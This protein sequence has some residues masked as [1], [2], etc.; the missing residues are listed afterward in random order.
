MN[1]ERVRPI[2]ILLIEDNDGDVF[3][4]RKAFEMAGFASNLIVAS[5]GETALKMLRKQEQY[6]EV[7]T[8]DIVLMDINLPKVDGKQ[9]LAEMK[10]DKCMRR[11]PIIVL[12]SSQAEQDVLKAYD[13]QANSYI[14]KPDDVEKFRALI[15]VIENFWFN[16]ALLPSRT[17]N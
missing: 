14:L 7:I 9:V 4:T 6:S 11:I 2:E 17:L 10:A 13:L 1:L 8:P 12:T 15:K 3:L 16:V 5:D